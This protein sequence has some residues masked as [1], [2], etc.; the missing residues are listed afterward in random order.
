MSKKNILVTGGAGY[1]GSHT[2]Y[3]LIDHG[4][5]PIVF[6][7]LSNGHK[8]I[9]SPDIKFFKGDI[10]NKE[11]F[12]TVFNQYKIQGV[13]NFAANPANNDDRWEN[14]SMYYHN[15]FLGALNL[16]EAADQAGIKNIVFSSTAAVYGLPES[17]P[18]VESQN[19]QPL[20]MYGQTKY[21]C[22]NLLRDYARVR[23][24]KVIPLRYFNACGGDPKLR[25]G[26]MHNPETHLIPII[27]EVAAGQREKLIMFGDDYD[28]RDGSCIRD[29][30]HVTDLAK[31]HV[32]ALQ[33]LELVE[34]SFF[35]A[36]N[37]GTGNGY[38]NKEIIETVEKITGKKIKVEVGA[39]RPGDWDAAY[40]D[41]TKAKI[42]LNW[43]PEY[44][45][46]KTII[47]TAWNWL[48]HS[49]KNRS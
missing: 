18:I 49:N 21:M 27:L 11:D 41:N 37:L 15:N 25:T 43:E 8:E 34:P 44:S 9:L 29:Y 17:L 35:E 24:A 14:Q 40:A 2:V 26:E 10:R 39:R 30:I 36:I 22:E 6:D 13:I 1:I 28:T 38:T 32:K 12:I 20:N 33:K 23:G 46:L 45:D 48:N 42:M 31:A 47:T 3:E 7:N 16:V 4:F 19:K 5:N